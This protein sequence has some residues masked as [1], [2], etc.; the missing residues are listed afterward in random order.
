M[1]SLVACHCLI[2]SHPLTVGMAMVTN[3]NLTPE[4]I[5]KTWDVFALNSGARKLTAENWS[6]FRVALDKQIA[7][8]PSQTSSSK[9]KKQKAAAVVS[10]SAMGKRS[11]ASST[12][13]TP[14]SSSSSLEASKKIK[15]DRTQP[16]SQLEQIVNGNV[17]S[18]PQK[19]S[20]GGGDDSVS[21]PQVTPPKSTSTTAP[22]SSANVVLYSERPNA[23]E[24]VLMFNPHNL[25][26]IE[27]S[28]EMGRRCVISQ[29]F[30]SHLS[31]SY[32]YMTD[33]NRHL[34][35]DRH[36]KSMEKKMIQS[37]GIPMS[38]SEPGGETEEKDSEEELAT[39]E[40]VGVPR[41]SLQTNI[42]RICNDA[43]DGKLNAT[44]LLLEGAR[45]GS[46]GAR[47]EL[48]VK[49]VS[50]YCLFQG[51]IVAVTGYNYNGR[52]MV[53]K[54]IKEG[55][56]C[57]G[58]EEKQ[59]MVKSPKEVFGKQG[60][61]VF[62]VAGPYTTSSD[63]EYQPLDDLLGFVAEEKPDVVL[64]MGPFVDMRHEIVK[65]GEDLVLEYQDGTKAH[66]CYEQFFAAK[67]AAELENMYAEDPDLKTQFVLVPSMDDAVS[68]P[69]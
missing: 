63:L 52:K 20:D 50:T 13:A 24:T 44:T 64:M 56:D 51:Q 30:S 57:K 36:L 48:D 61:K 46:N 34:S 68:E 11:S 67:I 6:S 40:N 1:K 58:Q 19:T 69:V 39:F 8:T 27:S 59:D 47:I 42:G 31:G 55:L 16:D 29:P 49:D 21:L 66:V 38:C 37:H 26:P 43:H 14:S 12:G 54:E 35:L 62:A 28:A 17:I 10:R 22:S 3:H 65:N 32:K 41:Q 45:H 9:K 5:A 60:V 15:L 7:K 53:A 4:D 33:A 25:P 23:G 2:L 18:S